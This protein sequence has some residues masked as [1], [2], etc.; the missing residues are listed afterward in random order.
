MQIALE[1][2]VY[3][4]INTT[5]DNYMIQN[6]GNDNIYIV[7]SDSQP[8]ADKMDFIIAPKCGISNSHVEGTVWGKPEGKYQIMVGVVEG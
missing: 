8:A 4:Q 6:L 1:P 5:T 7:I 3:T 2:N